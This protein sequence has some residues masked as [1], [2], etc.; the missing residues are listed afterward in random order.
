VK[1]FTRFENDVQFPGSETEHHSF[2]VFAA[3]AAVLSPM[4]E[5]LRTAVLDKLAPMR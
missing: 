2:L 3:G 5:L 1:G 4:Y